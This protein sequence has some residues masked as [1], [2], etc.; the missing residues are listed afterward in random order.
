MEYE[1]ISATIRKGKWEGIESEMIN[2]GPWLAAWMIE[3]QQKCILNPS[4]VWGP[5]QR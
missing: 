4:K 3:S 1:T 5:Y 2:R